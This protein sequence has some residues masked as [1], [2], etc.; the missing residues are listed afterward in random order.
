MAARRL[1]LDLAAEHAGPHVE[2][3]LEAEHP[4]GREIERLAV[5]EQADDEPSVALTIV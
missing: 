5:D 4:R 1:E 3:A 2:H